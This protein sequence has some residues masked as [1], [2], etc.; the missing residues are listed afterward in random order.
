MGTFVPVYQAFEKAS[1]NVA[2]VYANHAH[3]DFL[4]LWLEAGLIGLM[5]MVLFVVW[6]LL[7]SWRVWRRGL[8]G[9]GHLDNLLACG[10]ALGLMLLLVHAAVDY[11]LRAAALMAV[12]AWASAMAIAPVG[13]QEAPPDERVQPSSAGEG[14]KGRP[15]SPSRHRAEARAMT[16]PDQSEAAH[17]RRFVPAP[18]RDDWPETWQPRKKPSED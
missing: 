13:S 18:P 6:V 12:F 14:R 10:A 7:A 9:A 4:E 5:A 15:A 17:S 3:N 2:S 16:G 1:D 11:A 8:P